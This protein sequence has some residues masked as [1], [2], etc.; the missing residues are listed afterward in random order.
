[1][2]FHKCQYGIYGA[3]FLTVNMIWFDLSH[4]TSGVF[5]IEFNCNFSDF[6]NFTA[7]SS[8]AKYQKSFFFFL[9]K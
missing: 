5:E 2:F 3:N 8:F 7:S 9:V 4:W 6:S 1:M